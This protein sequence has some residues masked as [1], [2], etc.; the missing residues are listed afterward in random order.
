[1]KAIVHFMSS[2]PGRFVRIVAGLGLVGWWALGSGDL[3]VAAV[4]VLPLLTGILDICLFG[5]LF[6][7]PLGGRAVRATNG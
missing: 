1:M 6:G 3:V 4:G 7:M 5:P 2:T